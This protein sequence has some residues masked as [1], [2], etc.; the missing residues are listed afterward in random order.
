MCDLLEVVNINKNNSKGKGNIFIIILIFILIIML[1][2]VG[3]KFIQIRN[4]RCE[5][6]GQYYFCLGDYDKAVSE[7]NKICIYDF[8]HRRDVIA[9][10]N[11][12][13]SQVYTTMGKGEEYKKHIAVV[14]NYKGNNSEVLNGV[15][16]DRFYNYGI[17]EA[18]ALCENYLKDNYNDK[19]LAESMF[20]LYIINNEND[21]AKNV[22]KYYKIN[23]KSAYDFAEYSE[24]LMRIGEFDEGI[25]A[26]KKAWNIDKDEYRI[27]DVL[28]HISIYDKKS[29]VDSIEKYQ[30]D[31]L[32]DIAPMMWMAKIN[33]LDSD[34][35]EKANDLICKLKNKNVESLELNLIEVIT[36]NNMKKYDERNE[37]IEH[38]IEN[39]KDDYRVMHT[40]GWCYLENK[41]VDKAKECCLKSLK[42]NHEYVDNYAFLMPE[43]LKEMNKSKDIKPYYMI[44][45]F[46]EPYNV[47]VVENLIKYDLKFTKDKETGLYNKFNNFQ[48]F[49]NDVKRDLAVMRL[50][51]KKYDDAINLLKSALGN[52]EDKYMYHSELGAFYLVMDKKEEALKEMQKAFEINK[53]GILNLNNMACYYII[54]SDEY[55]KGYDM[56]STALKNSNDNNNDYIKESIN[57]NFEKAK[58]LMKKIKEGKPKEK[59]KVPNFK[60]LY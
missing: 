14:E 39:Y 19:K 24:M 23:E 4:Q 48:C 13:I 26:L 11:L 51:E 50:S 36:L 2:F 12:K 18:I 37:I 30:K 59:V 17:E 45:F 58:Y 32:N 15:I 42:N 28:S 33:S 8:K 49:S 55:S 27:Y 35:S 31:N 9:I 46:K 47:N 21:K 52:E 3:N 38:L 54:C 29:L 40:L 25:L 57:D 10:K 56:L 1:C 16:W 41:E 53:N 43:I 20:G 34:T 7:Y 6:R 60:V 5:I 22:L 44:A